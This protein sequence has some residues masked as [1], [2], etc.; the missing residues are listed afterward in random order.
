MMGGTRIRFIRNVPA[1]LTTKL[2]MRKIA[3]SSRKPCHPITGFHL[4]KISL[5][6]TAPNGVAAYFQT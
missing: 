1:Q 6:T 3:A 4:L 2:N 5:R